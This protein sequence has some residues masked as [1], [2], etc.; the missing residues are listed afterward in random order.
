MALSKLSAEQAQNLAVNGGE[1][2]T[3]DVY[4]STISLSVKESTS[5]CHHLYGMEQYRLM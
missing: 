2:V 4:R 5:T 1:D 3:S